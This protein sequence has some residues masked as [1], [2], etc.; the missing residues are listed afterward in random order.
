MS[1]VLAGWNRLSEEEAAQEIL[2][3]C[4]SEGWAHRVAARRPLKD[5]ASLLA[6]SDEIWLSLETP[7]WMEAFSKHPRIGERKAPPLAS[8]PS[9]AWSAEEQRVVASASDSVQ[10]ALAEGNREYERRFQRRFIVC[11]SG[12]SAPE[13]LGILRRRLQ[14]DEATELQEAVEEQRKITNIR[15]EKWI[16]G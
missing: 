10:L 2:A 4:G 7:D 13:L 1:H 5:E 8:A 14:N 15:L 3:C 16:L 12:K 6:A 11:A 9:A